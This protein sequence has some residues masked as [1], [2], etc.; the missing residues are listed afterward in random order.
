MGVSCMRPEK[1]E[2]RTWPE[3]QSKHLEIV[4]QKK[5]SGS[6]ETMD[7]EAVV[8]EV[9][10]KDMTCPICNDNYDQLK[11]AV[12]VCSESHTI[13][14]ACKDMLLASKQVKY[15]VC[16][17]CKTLINSSLVRVNDKLIQQGQ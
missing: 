8:K 6:A 14:Y 13:C 12:I 7:Q 15:R 1:V 11:M 10:S 16:P 2:Q 17:Y 4:L 5:R 9:T 3:F